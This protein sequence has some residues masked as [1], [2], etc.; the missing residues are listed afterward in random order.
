MICLKKKK[1]TKEKLMTIIIASWFESTSKI[2]GS[3]FTFVNES[4]P[5]ILFPCINS[6]LAPPPVEIKE[7]SFESPNEFTKLTESPPPITEVAPYFVFDTIA[8]SS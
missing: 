6:R 7:T 4:I 2:Q 8:F 3:S 5:G 1:K